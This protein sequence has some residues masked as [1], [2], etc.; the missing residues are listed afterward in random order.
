MITSE[1]PMFAFFRFLNEDIIN[2]IVVQTNKE[3]EE[4]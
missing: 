3:N 2:F 1:E 4:K